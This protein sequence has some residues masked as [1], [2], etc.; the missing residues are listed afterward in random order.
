MSKKIKIEWCEKWIEH[1]FEKHFTRYGL[2]KGGIETTLFWKLAEKSGLWE[3]GTYN[4]PMSKALSKLTVV[5]AV[6]NDDG[7]YC[8]SI[9]KLQN[10]EEK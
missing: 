5:E 6:N 3:R 7:Q 2:K 4:T 9:F 1:L 8:Y 10:C